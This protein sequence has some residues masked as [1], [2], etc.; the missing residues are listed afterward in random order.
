MS[1]P[2]INLTCSRGTI[3]SVATA[4]K[5]LHTVKSTGTPSKGL[6]TE[7]LLSVCGTEK[8][9]IACGFRLTA[10]RVIL[11]IMQALYCSGFCLSACLLHNLV[12]KIIC[13]FKTMIWVFFGR[14]KNYL[15]YDINVDKLSIP[16]S[17][18]IVYVLSIH[19]T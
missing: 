18:L 5:S 1:Q 15:E 14:I 16:F 6:Q 12:L 9:L 17:L 10:F 19:N 13:A 11:I 3:N 7:L 8:T 2:A 4:S